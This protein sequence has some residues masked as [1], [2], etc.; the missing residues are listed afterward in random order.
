LYREDR[1]P[2]S[3]EISFDFEILPFLQSVRSWHGLSRSEI[4]SKQTLFILMTTTLSFLPSYDAPLEQHKEYLRQ[5]VPLM[6]KHNIPP[7][8]INYAIWYNMSPGGTHR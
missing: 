3:V 4:P 2:V 5:C 8:P 1:Q 6:V 7:D